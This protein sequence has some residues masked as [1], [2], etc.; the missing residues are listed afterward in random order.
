MACPPKTPGPDLQEQQ[1]VYNIE[2]LP[3]SENLVK[4]IKSNQEEKYVI[5]TF[6]SVG[7]E[8]R[9]HKQYWNGLIVF[10]DLP[11]P[12]QTTTTTDNNGN[13]TVEWRENPLRKSY[14]KDIYNV[15]EVLYRRTTVNPDGS[16]VDSLD[17]NGD[18]VVNYMEAFLPNGDS[19]IVATDPLG[20]DY[21][22][23]IFEGTNDH[24]KNADIFR[25]MRKNMPGCDSSGSGAGG[26][27]DASNPYDEYMEGL[28]SGYES[29]GADELDG[30]T[31]GR[32]LD[33]IEINRPL[34][35]NVDGERTVIVRKERVYSDGTTI[36]EIHTIITNE[37]GFREESHTTTVNNPD[38][39]SNT[40]TLSEITYP[41]GGSQ[42]TYQYT[43][44]ESGTCRTTQTSDHY[45]S[46]ERSTTEWECDSNDVCTEPITTVEDPGGDT[47]HPGFEPD[48]NE[49]MAEFCETW[50]QSQED[51]PN[52]VS[53]LNDRANEERCSIEPDEAGAT[54][55]SSLAETCYADIEGRD[56]L[57]EMI[58]AGTCVTATGGAHFDYVTDGTRTCKKNKFFILEHGLLMN[59]PTGHSQIELCDDDFACTPGDF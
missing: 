11:L 9:I 38:G 1:Q 21:L 23:D 39:T 16:A 15:N 59:G 36:I 52:D 34:I 27:G 48:H 53:E 51:R 57:A 55:G 20:I 33:H 3:L 19:L 4:H 14:S 46:G 25:G 8:D 31:R 35:T 49:A 50:R 5:Y 26:A 28:C 42:D 12:D 41:D 45:P 29:S 22:K 32:R 47:G 43:E 37:E 6:Y 2:D 7:D 24:C 54:E 56:E 58:A 13:K 17:V 30:A 40:T 44:C 10:D 18:G